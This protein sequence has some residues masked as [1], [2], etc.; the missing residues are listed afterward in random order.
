[1]QPT[2]DVAVAAL[3]NADLRPAWGQIQRGVE[4][5][6]LRINADGT[7]ASSAH[8]AQ[9]GASLTHAM[10]TTDYAESLMEFITPVASNIEQTLAQLRDI[11]AVTYRALG[12]ELL[13]PV[14]MPCYVG[15]V[16]DIQVAQYGS[17]NSGRMKTL[18]RLGLTERYGAMMQI[19]AGVH[20]NF[21][22]PKGIWQALAELE[23][24]PL[25][26]RFISQRYFALIR[27]FKRVSWVIPYL[28]GASPAICESFVEHAQANL[29]FER[30]PNGSLYRPYA[31]SLRMSDLGYTNKEQAAL[32]ITYNSLDDYVA[33]LRRAI[34]TPSTQFARIGVKDG[35]Q[36]RQLNA[37]ILQI[38]NEFYATIRP[39]RVTKGNE[40]P[41]QA[42]ERGGVEYIEVRALDVNPFSDVGIT[43]EQMRFLDLLLFYCLLQP[44][45]E[46]SLQQQQQAEKN[47][48]KVVL[49]GRDPRLS[50]DDNGQSRAMVDWL[51]E[52]FA[53][54]QL[55]VPL[56]DS[57]N[58][59][60]AYA[61]TL[62]QLYQC[63][64]NPEL[65]LSGQV[66]SI[67][68][69]GQSNAEL[70]LRLAQQYKAELLEHRLTEFSE[71]QFS[72]WAEQ[73]IQARRQRETD[74]KGSD[75]SQFLTTYFA[76][77]ARAVD[78][79]DDS[80]A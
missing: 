15:D 67:L 14:S 70:A 33:G 25:N 74:D 72:D 63:V 54:L 3:Q 18:Y 76:N 1:M 4:R 7:L 42:L 49:D 13:W 59:D 69:D 73:S 27:N 50:L 38:E 80:V 52:L 11:H 64:L 60:S 31:T 9:L 22:V 8:P 23:Q 44:S 24:A 30:L 35:E 77:A 58:N 5:E 53:D 10:I 66:L 37:N 36:Y 26:Q 62:H 79:L 2:F 55:L 43:A 32:G 19:I 47:F 17:S 68:R 12:D 61:Q 48:N 29:S 6:A 41:T 45:A 16:A 57:A 21:S 40:T 75:F 65:T 34:S 56:L 71:Q 46:M 51:E 28:F 20:Y 78:A 39:K